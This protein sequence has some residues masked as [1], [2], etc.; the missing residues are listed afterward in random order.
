MVPEEQKREALDQLLQSRTLLRCDQLKK[1]LRFVCEAEIEGR[2]EELNEYTIGVE[3]LGRPASFN[4]VEDSTV[5]T[6]A[7]ELRHKLTR[8][9]TAE[10]PEAPI[11]IEIEKGTYAPRFIPS[12]NVKPNGTPQNGAGAPAQP[13]PSRRRWLWRGLAAANVIVLVL[14]AFVLIRALPSPRGSDAVS[15]TPEMDAFWR[16]FL[17][18]RTS[19]MVTYQARLFL[20]APSADL[21]VRHWRTNDMSE[22]PQSEPLQRFRKQMGITDFVESRNFAD[23][24]AVNSVFLLTQLLGPRQPRIAL[25]GSKDLDWND[26]SNNNVIFIGHGDVHPRLRKLLE[27]GDFEE[28]IV[29][30]RNRRPRQG[31][32]AVYHIAMGHPGVNDGEKYAL[33]SRFP[34]PQRG[35]YVLML[36]AAHSELPWAIAE[37]ITNPLSVRDLVEHLRQPNGEIPDAFQVVLRVTLQSQVPVRVQYATHH[38]VNAPEFGGQ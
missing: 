24:G 11:Q 30:I 1:L 2:V 32:L 3:A 7:Y 5:R 28:R 37:Y 35:R 31:E 33:L 20:F 18:A 14:A 21:Q 4:P 10:S 34:G 15:W 19:L 23:F 6:R 29:G 9:Y 22:V 36:G 13:V 25:K 16:P 38:V 26:I 27:D 8:F 12:Q 17:D